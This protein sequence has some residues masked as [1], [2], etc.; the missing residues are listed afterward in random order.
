MRKRNRFTSVSAWLFF[1]FLLFSFFFCVLSLQL[2][3][4]VSVLKVGTWNSVWCS[5]LHTQTNTLS[6]TATTPIALHHLSCPSSIELPLCASL[7]P[8]WFWCKILVYHSLALPLFLLPSASYLVMLCS[9]FCHWLFFSINL[10][11]EVCEYCF[12]FFGNACCSFIYIL[13]V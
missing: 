12:F 10:T 7:L 4:S 2:L 9:I 11:E 5:W 8:L 1:F 13:W 6:C 3:A